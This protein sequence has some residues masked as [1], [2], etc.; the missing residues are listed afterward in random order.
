MIDF[1]KEKFDNYDPDSGN[2]YY[3][4]LKSAEEYIPPKTRVL[5]ASEVSMQ[6]VL[7]FNFMQA[8]YLFIPILHVYNT[9]T[10]YYRT[11]CE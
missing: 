9:Y 11:K 10:Q 3:Q 7:N 6:A 4:F 2:G 5:L 8:G 1:A